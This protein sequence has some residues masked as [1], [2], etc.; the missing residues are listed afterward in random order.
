MCCDHAVP[1]VDHTRRIT[2]EVGVSQCKVW[3]IALQNMCEV[4]FALALPLLSAAVVCESQ[5]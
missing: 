5:Y 2:S 1:V 4:L 3:V